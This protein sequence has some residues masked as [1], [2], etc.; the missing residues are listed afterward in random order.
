MVKIKTT[1][2]GE[3]IMIKWMLQ[4]VRL[5][6]VQVVATGQAGWSPAIKEI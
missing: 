5:V 3:E 2:N 6:A 4:P 1:K